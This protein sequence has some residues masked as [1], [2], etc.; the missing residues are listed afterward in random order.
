MNAKITEYENSDYQVDM[1]NILTP[2]KRLYVGQR[3]LLLATNRVQAIR[4]DDIS[5]EDD[6]II[7][8]VSRLLD[9][10]RFEISHAIEPPMEQYV[11]WLVG[12]KYIFDAVEQRVINQIRGE[13]LLDFQ[14]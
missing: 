12:Y 4:I 14:F 3:L 13:E 7:I 8:Q 6:A 10:H 5:L 1:P 9:G 2:G 11:W